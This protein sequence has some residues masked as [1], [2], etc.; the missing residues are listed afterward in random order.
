MKNLK[1]IFAT[2]LFIIWGNSNA[3]AQGC[4]MCKEMAKSSTQSG[5]DVSTGINTGILYLMAIPYLILMIG[6]YLFFKKD[7]DEK[8]KYLK[9]KFFASKKI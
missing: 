9:N 1:L 7:V 5:S 8:I 3:F 2:L 6:G 4:A